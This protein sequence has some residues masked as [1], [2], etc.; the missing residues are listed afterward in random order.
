MYGKHLGGRSMLLARRLTE[1]GV[2]VVQVCCA[3]GDLNGGAGDMW[4]THG[5]NFNRLK[6]RLLPVF[7]QG[8][9]AL[10]QDLEN[11]GSLDQTLVVMLTD[12]G[13]TPRINGGAGRDHYPNVYSVALAGGGVRG[14]QVYGSSDNHGAFPRTQPCGP[15]DIHATIFQALGLSP[16]AEL[17]DPLGRPF[18]ATDGRVLPLLS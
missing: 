14:G 2:P 16:R 18:P 15:A 11:R 5:D 10:L 17:R 4:D 6:N 13:R 9:A 12:F 3:A 8:A 7:D 1:A